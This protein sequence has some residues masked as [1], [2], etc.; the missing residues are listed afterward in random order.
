MSSK[1]YGFAGRGLSRGL[2]GVAVL[3][4]LTAWSTAAMATITQGDFSIFG[5][6]STRWSGRWGEGS[7][8]GGTAAPYIPIPP[9]PRTAYG[10]IPGQPI[11]AGSPAT[12]TGGS[13]D[14]NHWDLVQARQL[15]DIRPDYHIV[16]NFSFLG[17]FD[18]LLLED[19][20]VFAVYKPWYDAFPDIKHEG[21]A[22]TARDWT[23]Y[24]DQDKVE[25]FVRND[26]RE[27]YG[28]LNFS[29]D[30]SA[31]VGKQQVIWSE[32][33]ALSGTDVTNPT[34]LRYHWTHFE[35]AEDERVNLRM[36]KLNYVFPDFLNTA[37]NELDAFIIPGDWEGGANLVNT[38]D[39]RS[40]YDA[41]AAVEAGVGTVGYNQ[42]GQPYRDQT[43]ADGDQYPLHETYSSTLAAPVFLD[44]KVITHVQGLSN[45]LDNSEFGA[46]YST[47][48]PIGN[49]LQTSLIYLYEA[50]SDKLQWCASCKNPD[51][52]YYLSAFAPP[53]GNAVVTPGEGPPGS[54]V[55]FSVPFIAALAGVPRTSLIY[56]APKN[57][58]VGAVGNLYINL[59]DEYVRQSYFDVTGT[60]YD[61]DLTDIV[62]RYDAV[63]SPKQAVNVPAYP[64]PKAPFPQSFFATGG[65]PYT[66]NVGARWTDYT[67][68]I[69]ACDRPTYIPWLS[70][71]HTFI[72]FQ[73]TETWYPDRPNGSVFGSP[74]STSKI[75]ETSTLSVLAFTNWLINGQLTAT[76]I[77][78][79]DWDNGVG[80]VE[81][82]NNYRYSRNILLDLNAIWYLG[83]SGRYTDPFL[84][85]RDQRINE[86]EV[87]F[88]YE[89]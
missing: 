21:I 10:L 72:T 50:R 59:V 68:W 34:D 24:T 64:P 14:F 53:P 28:Q 32:A 66:S 71:Q 38:S 76:N 77:G 49:G 39:P 55:G 35:S 73:Q 9:G 89:I 75:R 4:L 19:A 26:L 81:S 80:Y 84:F 3:C 5:Q 30:F 85:S 61:K 63:Y 40:P 51:P 41:Q 13:F 42:Y 69:F 16:K 48:I 8:H 83:R 22:Q 43:L 54:L 79:W 27:Y 87:R 23:P 25:Q 65:K 52:K 37:N 29:D 7:A 86:L 56:G 12:R 47:L 18:T 78:V 60:Y 62:Y 45:S 88:T 33:D 11:A 20:D 2:A 74:V 31:R 15:A 1:G 67:R 44:E 82:E 70:K 46:R 6:L 57:P 17:R 36:I 58:L